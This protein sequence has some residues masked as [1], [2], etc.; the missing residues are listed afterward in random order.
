MYLVTF[1]DP[2]TK[3]PF[4]RLSPPFILLKRSLHL[5][6]M[7]GYIGIYSISIIGLCVLLLIG[8]VLG[9]IVFTN[10]AHFSKFQPVV[11]F[12]DVRKV[13]FCNNTVPISPT[14]SS[15]A[16][17]CCSSDAPVSRRDLPATQSI[18]VQYGLWKRT[19]IISFAAILTTACLCGFLVFA[20]RSN[21]VSAGTVLHISTPTSPVPEK[22]KGAKRVFFYP[23]K[24][25]E[26][27]EFFFEGL[28]GLRGGT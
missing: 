7:T 4:D 27:S 28:G 19:L 8:I 12:T 26:R 24:T 2:F 20:T 5:N 10:T 13:M 17:V 25:K 11:S 22:N 16:S 14:T 23:K 18:V 9:P 15:M 1:H 21:N 3:K 6:V